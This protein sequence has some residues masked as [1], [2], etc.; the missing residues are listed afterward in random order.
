ML[1]VTTNKVLDVSSELK[2]EIKRNS[3]LKFFV[4]EISTLIEEISKWVG[5][6]V[7]TTI[8]LE[9]DEDVPQYTKI[10]LL[11]DIQNLKFIEEL[12]TWNQVMMM[13]GERISELIREMDKT[14]RNKMI[15]L[16][17]RFYVRLKLK[18]EWEE[19]EEN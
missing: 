19:I 16:H 2:N 5:I 11:L 12:Q 14:E 17:S 4:A 1:K 9:G 8:L 6:E 10:I 7:K 18:Q 15:D 3:L 13:M